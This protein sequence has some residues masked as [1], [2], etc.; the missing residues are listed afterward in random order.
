MQE[1]E[2]NEGRASDRE[3]EATSKET[4]SDLEKTEKSSSSNAQSSDETSVPT[5]DGQV[6]NLSDGRAD[7][8]DTGGP[9]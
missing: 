7:G 2:G 3:S 6:E 4:V 8:S 1:T 5:P 9:M